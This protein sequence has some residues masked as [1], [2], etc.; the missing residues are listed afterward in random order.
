ME[1]LQQ[2]LMREPVLRHPDFARL[3]KIQTDASYE[4]I[5]AVLSQEDDQR[6]EYVVAYASRRIT[7]AELKWDTREKEAL[8]IVW[9]CDHYRPYILGAP[10]VVET[11]H[12]SLQWLMKVRKGRLARW[13]L[14]LQEFITSRCEYLE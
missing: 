12:A 13:A 14:K 9:A 10:F 4:G 6:N 1:R 7:E 11:D 3:F 8:A 2:V 5:A